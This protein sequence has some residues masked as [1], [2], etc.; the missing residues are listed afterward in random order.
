MVSE[1]DQVQPPAAQRRRP[2]FCLAVAVPPT[3]AIAELVIGG[4]VANIIDQRAGVTEGESSLVR[5]TS[6]RIPGSALISSPAIVQTKNVGEIVV[7]VPHAGGVG[8]S[9]FQ[10]NGVPNVLDSIGLRT[11]A[12]PFRPV[13]RLVIMPE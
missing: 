4:E 9:I 8:L 6:Q 12:V 1:S 3:A 13:N 11:V 2:V 5:Q 10:D 7:R